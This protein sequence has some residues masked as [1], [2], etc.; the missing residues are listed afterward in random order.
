MLFR[1]NI[2][3]KKSMKDIKQVKSLDDIA[4]NILNVPG[5]ILSCEYFG[6][7]SKNNWDTYSIRNVFGGNEIIGF[8]NGYLT[9]E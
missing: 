5:I 6:F 1:Y 7:D 3:Y 8:V 2:P 4:N 9:K